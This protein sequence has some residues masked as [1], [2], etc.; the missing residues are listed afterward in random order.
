M[1]HKSTNESADHFVHRDGI[2]YAGKHLLLDF[3]GAEKLDDLAHMEVALRA[4]ID[5]AK[6]TLIHIHL[7]HFTPNNGISGIAVLAESH[8]SV[9]TWPG[10]GFAA[11]DVFM[12]GDTKPELAVAV[13]K[14]A[15]SPEKIT[16]TE[17]L[18]G[19]VS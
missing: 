1:N 6:A 12:C 13:L 2:E 19:I 8:I 4:A 3:W 9:H 16:V 5:A 15:L 14:Q 10:R 17:Q 7:H 11:F 18:R